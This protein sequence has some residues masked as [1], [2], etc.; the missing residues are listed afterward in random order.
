MERME[1]SVLLNSAITQYTFNKIF[2]DHNNGKKFNMQKW[3]SDI[4]EL[5]SDSMFAISADKQ[6]KLADLLENLDDYAINEQEPSFEG[7]KLV[8][9]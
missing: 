1:L 3:I 9:D 8:L 6:N 4:Q 5:T 7:P 2:E